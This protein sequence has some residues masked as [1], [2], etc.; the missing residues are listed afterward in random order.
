MQQTFPCSRCGSQNYIGQPFCQNCGRQF[1][2]NCPSCRTIVESRFSTCPNCRAPLNWP[3]QQQVQPPPIY[4]KEQ[5]EAVYGHTKEEPKRKKINP[6]LIGLKALLPSVILGIIFYFLVGLTQ[7]MARIVQTSGWWF[8]A[9]FIVF[10][11][12][13]V[14]L[15]KGEKILGRF[16]KYMAYEFWAA[17]IMMIIYT[18]TSVGQASESAGAAGGIGAGIGGTALVIMAVIIGGF[19]GLILFLIGNAITKRKHAKSDLE[20]S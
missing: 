10:E 12:L 4:Q 6:W 18:V 16:L 14:L 2:Y 3:I 8:W 1:Q 13:L 7:G 19:G 20:D 11:I 15:N 17:P 9:G 5:Q